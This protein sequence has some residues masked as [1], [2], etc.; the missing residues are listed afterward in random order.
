M[1]AISEDAINEIQTN[2]KSSSI[3]QGFTLMLALYITKTWPNWEYMTR[4]VK[5]MTGTGLFRIHTF[6]C[7]LKRS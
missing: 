2:D 1:I 3:S 4:T 7:C 5:L 6:V